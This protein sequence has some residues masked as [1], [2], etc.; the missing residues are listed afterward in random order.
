MHRANNHSSPNRIGLIL[1]MM[2]IMLLAL[3]APGRTVAEE[4]SAYPQRVV[5][6]SPHGADLLSAAGGMDRLVGMA[7]HTKLPPGTPAPPVLGDANHLDRERLMMLAPQLAIAWTSGNRHQDLG[8]LEK[9]GV[10]IFHSDPQNLSEIATEIEAL[11]ALLGTRQPA[12]KNAIRV[13]DRI[14]KLE[15]RF[16]TRP[17]QPY[18]FQLWANPPMTIGGTSLISRALALCGLTNAFEKIPRKAFEVNTE[19]VRLS[20]AEVELIPDDLPGAKPLSDARRIIRVP[21]SDLY[22]P[23]PRMLDA[24]ESVC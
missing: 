24:V 4:A 13:R 11:G 6:L 1:S 12:T 23:T 20:R 22:Q 3:A 21:A 14:A 5:T 19:A 18:F 9:Q 8:W 15:Q 10:R 16:A 7:A 2:A 17:P